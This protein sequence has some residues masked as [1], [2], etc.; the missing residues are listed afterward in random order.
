MLGLGDDCAGSAKR[1]SFTPE[2]EDKRLGCTDALAQ[3]SHRLG[4]RRFHINTV[5]NIP[6]VNV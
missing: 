1:L 5:I 4:Y 2:V 3:E 6:I